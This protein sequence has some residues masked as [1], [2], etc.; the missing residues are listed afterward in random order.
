MNS[1]TSEMFAKGY[2]KETAEIVSMGKIFIVNKRKRTP[3]GIWKSPEQRERSIYWTWPGLSVK[4]RRTREN[5]RDVRQGDSKRECESGEL[6]WREREGWDAGM[7]ALRCAR[8]RVG[9]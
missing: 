3:R 5:S 6:S 4:G 7:E 1:L 8:T 2:N 9:T